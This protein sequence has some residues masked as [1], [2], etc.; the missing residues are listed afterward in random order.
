VAI[1]RAETFSRGLSEGHGQLVEHVV[2]VEVR[3]GEALCCLPCLRRPIGK[4]LFDDC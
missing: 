1:D 3:G 2:R 4:Q